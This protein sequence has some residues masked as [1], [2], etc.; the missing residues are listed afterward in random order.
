[1]WA[2]ANA[3]AHDAERTRRA[4]ACNIERRLIR[5]WLLAT[6]GGLLHRIGTTVR[7]GCRPTSRSAV[8]IPTGALRERASVVIADDERPARSWRRARSFEDVVLVA[9]AE[10]GKEAVAA[11][12]RERLILRFWIRCQ[13][14]GIGV[15]RML[16]KT[17][18]P[19]R[20]RH[21]HA[22]RRAGVRGER[23]RLSLKPVEKTRRREALNRAWAHRARRNRRGTEPPVGDA[24]A[25][26]ICARPTSSG[27]RSAGVTKS[28]S[29]PCHR[30]RRS[31]PK[32]SC[33]I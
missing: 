16:K 22:I 9:E 26:Q 7:S 3:T 21:G 28:S 10:T 27:F 1:M 23:G 33:S 19:D 14:D 15:V 8:A 31:S 17:V 4:S 24:I 30:L 20:V 11:I 12:E 32:A 18:M 13:V 2:G 6:L 29:S 5:Q 25:A